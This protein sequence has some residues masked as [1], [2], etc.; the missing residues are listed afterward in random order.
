MQSGTGG[1]GA[2]PDEVVGRQTMDHSLRGVTEYL[3]DHIPLTKHIGATVVEMDDTSVRLHAPI[4]KNINHRETAFGGSIVSLGILAG[5]T[6]LHLKLTEA[7]RSCRLVIQQST[8]DFLQPVEEDFDAVV[9]LKD[10]KQWDKFTRVLTK[11]GKARINLRSEIQF[12]S[13]TA[14]VVVGRYV[15][16]ESTSGSADDVAP[17]G[18]ET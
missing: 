6:L 16:I 14:A 13:Q 18:E 1:L 2:V 17:T 3:H 12:A 9:R 8:T 10:Q 5:W 15:A 7:G 11:K 4:S